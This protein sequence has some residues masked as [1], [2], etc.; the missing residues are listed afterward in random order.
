M[1][2]LGAVRLDDE[3]YLPGNEEH[4]EMLRERLTDRQRERLSAA[5]VITG[6]GSEV[7]VDENLTAEEAP[8]KK[9]TTKKQSAANKA[10]VTKAPS[11]KKKKVAKKKEAG[12]APW[13]D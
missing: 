3:V 8:V 10:P 9:K 5:G 2:I 6:P 1:K 13:N 12:S 11:K 4:A 7:S